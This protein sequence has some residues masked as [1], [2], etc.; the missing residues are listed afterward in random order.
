MG[1]IRRMLSRQPTRWDEIW[2][3]YPGTV[4]SATAIWSV[5]LGAV[6]AAPLEHLPVRLD[7][8]APYAAGP[9]GLPV[10]AVQ[11]VT[12]EDSVRASVS[13]LGGAYIG[14]LATNGRCRFTAHLPAMPD[15]AVSVAGVAAEG[16]RAEYDPHWAYVRDA[17]APDERQ[18]RLL[19]DRA[20]LGELSVQGDELAT[21]RAVE[22]V[23]FF[24]EQAPAE[25]AA[26]DLRADGFSASV[27][28]DDEGAFAL[29]AL[30]RDPVAPPTVHDLAW[31]VQETV[32]RHGGVYDGWQCAV[33]A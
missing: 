2:H 4:G 23:A 29:T 5:D 11:L 24:A 15:G 3:T 16:V 20:L 10:D 33:A 8:D 7:V 1:L 17:L 13:A 14:R 27:E 21:P 30:R 32:E 25:E 18:H 26:A 12:V 9:D 6:E 19:Q 28:R 31:S 22:H